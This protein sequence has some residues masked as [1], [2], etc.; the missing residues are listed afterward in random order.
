MNLK[1]DVLDDNSIDLSD[2]TYRSILSTRDFIKEISIVDLIS[3][4]YKYTNIV[5][6]NESIN[7]NIEYNRDIN[8]CEHLVK[9]SVSYSKKG[10]IYNKNISFDSL[11]VIDGVNK[12]NFLIKNID[13]DIIVE[14]TIRCIRV[15]PNTEDITACVI[16]QCF[17]IYE[18]LL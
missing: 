14:Y 11:S 2:E 5:N 3:T 17:L 12:D 1:Y 9:L 16:N 8:N 15:F 13:N 18:G 6:L 4:K 7:L 10:K